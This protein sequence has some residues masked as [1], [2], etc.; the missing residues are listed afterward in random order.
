M[1]DI[2]IIDDSDPRVQYA[3]PSAW[4]TSGVSAEYDGATHFAGNAGATATLVFVGEWK[5]A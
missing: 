1:A 4:G 5:C 2:T 3:L